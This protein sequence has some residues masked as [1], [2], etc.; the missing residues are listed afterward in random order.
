MLS[1]VDSWIIEF[2]FVP[3]YCSRSCSL[4]C[5]KFVKERSIFWLS[6]CLL[7]LS[8]V[9]GKP[10]MVVPS[11]QSWPLQA[12]RQST[13]LYL[14]GL[15]I[16]LVRDESSEV[17]WHELQLLE[18]TNARLSNREGLDRPD[19]EWEPSEEYKLN[20]WRKLDCIAPAT[21]W[22]HLSELVYYM[23]QSCLIAY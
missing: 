9:S 7:H 10:Y 19:Q 14:N 2:V 11:F 6:L 18:G 1:F 23:V 22:M 8:R 12:E 15:Y 17:R 3:L 21:I 4:P 13:D 16:H 5:F 20:K